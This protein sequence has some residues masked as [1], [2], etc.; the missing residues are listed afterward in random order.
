MKRAA[1]F[2]LLCV[3]TAPVARAGL[4]Q[5]V[6]N[7]GHPIAGIIPHREYRVQV[8]LT[9]ESSLQGGVRLGFKDRVQ[10]G[11]FYGVQK[12]VETGSPTANDHLGFEV[13]A[14][15]LEEARWPAVAVGFDSQGWYAYD[16][17]YQR[18]ERKSPGVYAVAS[19]NWHSFAGDLSLHLGA[20]YSLETADGD[21]AP[22]M[23]G[24]ADWTIANAVSLLGDLDMAW[25]DD[26]PDGR[27]G[28]GGVYVDVGVRVALGAHLQLMLVFSDL[29][30][31]LGPDA[32]I[33]RELEV[34]YLNWF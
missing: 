3:L 28:E 23:F 5:P 8:R 20:N 7:V 31:N 19:K 11:V 12:L 33:G 4:E 34:T 14:R 26:T 30:R 22:D 16:G 2:A 13:R 18:Y 27:F 25:N 17:A 6:D 29:T 24:A 21:D 10:V 15:V 9:P 32:E 1:A